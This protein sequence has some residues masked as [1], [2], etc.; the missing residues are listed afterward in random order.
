LASA[1]S[2]L[3]EKV[4]VAACDGRIRAK[5]ELL[6]GK[7]EL[8]KLPWAMQN[9]AEILESVANLKVNKIRRASSNPQ[10][11]ITLY[12]ANWVKV[13]TGRPHYALLADLIEAA[14]QAS[15]KKPPKWINRLEIE[16]NREIKCRAKWGQMLLSAPHPISAGQP[17]APPSK[18]T[19]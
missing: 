16:M 7:P 15:V 9:A 4:R 14:F 12:L 2:R 19:D 17:P 13:C 11:R 5:L 6:P 3:S 8:W 18:L 1:L 10:V